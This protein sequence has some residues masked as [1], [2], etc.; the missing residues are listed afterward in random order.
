MRWISLGTQ[1]SSISDASR[2]AV[3]GAGIVLTSAVLWSRALR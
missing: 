1:W 2:L 3:A